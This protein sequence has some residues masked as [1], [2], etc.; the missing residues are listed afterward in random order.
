MIYPL[1]AIRDIK[2][3]FMSPNADQSEQSAIRNFAYAVN[4]E[5]LMNYSPKDFDL[6][7]VGSFDSETGALDPCVVQLVCSGVDVFEDKK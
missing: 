1:F 7:K 6:Y 5:G 4:S 3:G 2:V